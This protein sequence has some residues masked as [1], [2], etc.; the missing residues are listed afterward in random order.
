M[1]WRIAAALALLSFGVMWVVMFRPQ[2]LGGPA[3]Y[4]GVSGISMTPTL[5]DGDL[6]VAVRH[7]SYQEGDIIVFHVPAGATDAGLQVIHRIVGGNGTTG[8]VTEGD[9]NPGPDPWHPTSAYVVGRVWFVVPGKV[10]WLIAVGGRGPAGA[11]RDRRLAIEAEAVADGGPGG[12][13]PVGGGRARPARFWSGGTRP[14]TAIGGVLGQCDSG[15]RR[16]PDAGARHVRRT[17]DGQ[18]LG[19]GRLVLDSIAQTGRGTGPCEATVRAVAKIVRS[20]GVGSEDDDAMDGG[21]RHERSDGFGLVGL[22]V[23]M[24]ILGLMALVAIQ[25]IPTGTSTGTGVTPLGVPGGAASPSD[26][27]V[28]EGGVSGA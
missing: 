13:H 11:P 18:H 10:R 12:S 15:R 8:F 6:T 14:S 17:G 20:S 16:G 5:H 9:H 4:A 21:T 3:Q 25:A 28:I 7:A 24:A 23:S 2:F 1:A 22:L 26:P 27:R 19:G